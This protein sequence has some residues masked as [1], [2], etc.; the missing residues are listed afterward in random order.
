MPWPTTTTLK[1]VGLEHSV[2]GAFVVE[3]G[4]K[5]VFLSLQNRSCCCACGI[6]RE[7]SSM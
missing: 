2:V 7:S 5:F 4:V 1:A 6:A 3:T